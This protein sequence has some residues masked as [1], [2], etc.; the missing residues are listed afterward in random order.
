M[1][2]LQT[3]NGSELHIVNYHETFYPFRIEQLLHNKLFEKREHGEWFKLD[4]HDIVSF[5]QY[6]QEF[7]ELIEVMKDNPFFAKNLR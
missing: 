1:K 5:K 3:G 6:C 7:E 2:Q 4:L